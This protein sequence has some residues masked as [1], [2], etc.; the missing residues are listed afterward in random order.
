MI[1]YRDSLPYKV[2]NMRDESGNYI[3]TWAIYVTNLLQELGF[4]YLWENG[5]ITHI[6][7]RMV[8]SRLYE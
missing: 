1:N 8:I 7:L 4:S 2:F 5:N 6:Q 3:N